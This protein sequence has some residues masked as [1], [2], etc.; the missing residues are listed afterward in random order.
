MIVYQMDVKTGFLNDV[1]R[2]EVYVSQPEG[3]VD[4]DHPNYVYR[5]K[6]ALYGLKQA[7][8]AWYDMLSKFL[9][10]QKFSKGAVD[11]TLFT[12]K[13]GK[14]ILLMSMMGKLSFFLG[15]QISQTPRGIFINQSTHAL[16]ITNK[17]GMESS[18]PVDTPMVERTKP[19]EDPQGILFEPTRYH[20]TRIELTAYE[21]ADHAGCQ[22][23]RRSTSSSAQFLGDKL[24]ENGVVE[25]YFVRMKYQLADIFTKALSRERFEFLLSHL[26]MQSMSSETLKHLAKSEEI[27]KMMFGIEDSHHGP[28]DAM[29]NPSQPLKS[30]PAKVESSTFLT[31]FDDEEGLL[32]APKLQTTIDCHLM[33]SNVTPL[34]WKGYLD[35]RLDAELLD[36]HD[37]C[38]IRKVVVDNAVNQRARE[39]L[40]MANQ[41]K[42]ECKVLKER[43]KSRDREDEELRLKCE[44]AMIKFENNHVI[45]VLCQKMKSLSDEVKEHKA[46]M[47]RMLLESQKLA[48]YQENLATLELKVGVLEAEKGRLEAVEALL[49][50][51]VEAVKCDRAKL[52]SKLLPYVAMELVQSDEMVILVGNLV[53]SA[54]FFGRCAAFEE[55]ASTKEPFDLAKVKYY[56]PLYKKEHTKAGND[57]A[58]ATFSFLSKVVAYPFASV[59]ALNSKKPK[60]LRRPTPTK[61][62]A[63][64][65]LAPSQKATPSS[66]PTS[67]P[68]SPSPA[69]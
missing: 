65:L 19:D 58:T 40:K 30:S 32:E 33:I 18:D 63:P 23:T 41:M 43:E 54:I 56:R 15:L 36:L 49:R 66:A 4:Q 5:L 31:I 38:Y 62:H 29:H 17:Y 12:R 52:V 59:K 25:L 14:D 48:G 47:D 3:F 51:E 39:L 2:E 37:R 22:D 61:T 9:L 35:N 24:V 27:I 50:Q 16:E 20:G 57:L 10:S 11:P 53:S 42:G 26:R 8:R 64:A 68:M 55:V 34:V 60:S 69:I 67:K 21:D 13:E 44:A 28:S 7:P 46:S 6:K 1:L 45:S